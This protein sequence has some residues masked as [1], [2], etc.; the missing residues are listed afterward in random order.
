MFD[1]ADG[2]LNNWNQHFSKLLEFLNSEN[3]VKDKNI[4]T[5]LKYLRTNIDVISESKRIH[6]LNTSDVNNKIITN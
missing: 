6:V 1:N 3:H 2:L 4:R 5:V